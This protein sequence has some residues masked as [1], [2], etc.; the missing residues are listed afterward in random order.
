MC[1]I[2]GGV[3]QKNI[4]PFLIQGLQKL[5]YRGYDSCGLAVH[6]ASKPGHLAQ[7]LLRMR[8]VRRVSDLASMA[9]D[10]HTGLMGGTGI[11]HTRWA[12]HG[13]PAICNAHPHFSHGPKAD[14]NN[15]PRVAVVH[16]GI[17]ENH[18]ELRAPLKERGY[19][20]KSQTD[21]EVVAHLLD[22]TNEGDAIQA[23]RRT[24][25]MLKGAYALAIMFHDQPDRII[26]TR[27]GSPL[28]L[29]I[30]HDDILLASDPMALTNRTD[31]IVY[32][33][34]GDLVDIQKGRY[35]ITDAKGVSV[36]RPVQTVRTANM[37]TELNGH[38][39]HM[40][41]EIFDQ[42]DILRQGLSSLKTLTPDLFEHPARHIGHACAETIFESID[43]ILILG[44]GTSYYS[45]CTAK[46]WLEKI[47]RIPTQV[48]VASEY[49]Y[50]DSLPNPKSLVIAV[51]Q[52]GETADTLAA[53]RHAQLMGMQH[54][55]T[56]C[57][58]STSTMVRECELAF[59]T[60]AGPEVGVASTKAFTTQLLGWYLL[61]LTL[62][63]QRGHLSPQQEAE[64]LQA[65]RQLP[66]ALD[67]VLR[68][69]PE[70]QDWAKTLS[71]HDSAIFLGRGIH[72]P[73]A[74]E[75]ALKLKE[76]SYIHAEAFSAGELKHGPLALISPQMP[77]VALVPRDELISKMG[78]N[79]QEVSARGG[80]L[81][82]LADAKATLE[83]TEQTRIIRLPEA[84]GD[85]SPWLHVVA[86]QLLAYHT[87]RARGTDIDKPRN[88]AKSVTVE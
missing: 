17:I 15:A 4:V 39:H 35:A 47:A 44:C 8:S 66:H 10:P 58:V 30:G 1:G 79:L 68:L 25:G 13:A 26:A 71:Q 57:N 41:Q 59:I 27:S 9:E 49:R 81:F 21:T 88:L 78:S 64:K 18:N 76:I 11:A 55:M 3:S 6:S 69:E 82:V 40:H 53:L 14:L 2:I 37:S 56:I 61:A 43:A 31:Q 86:L 83:P 46:Y 74:Q 72:H 5:E 24:L 84:P 77:V 70:L 22:A 54:T 67:Q 19:A 33:C 20:F 45:A 60:Q 34:D 42:P 36:I 52:S 50:R 28:V 73:I 29:G 75:G 63:K 7:R 12:T 48:E 16:N 32:L 38:E 65:L 23:V 51:S 80:S 85:T 87:A 62:A